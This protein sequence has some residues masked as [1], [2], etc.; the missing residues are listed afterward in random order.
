ME[1]Y[2]LRMEKHF[3]VCVAKRSLE[4]IVQNVCSPKDLCFKLKNDVTM[5][6]MAP[7]FQ[8]KNNY[9]DAYCNA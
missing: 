9:V 2:V 8:H 4:K 3:D 5:S 7:A 6:T 1:V